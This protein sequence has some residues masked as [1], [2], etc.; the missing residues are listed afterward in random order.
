[1]LCLPQRP[2][3]LASRGHG[4]E[5]EERAR[6][7]GHRDSVACRH[8]VADEQCFVESQ[9]ASLPS[10]ARDGDVDATRVAD[11]QAPQS[12][13]GPMTQDPPV[14][15]SED[16]GHPDAAL[17]ELSMADGVDATVNAMEPA[18]PDAVVDRAPAEAEPGELPRFDEPVLALGD[19]RDRL[20]R[21]RG[22][23]CS[24]YAMHNVGRVGG[25]AIAASLAGR[26]ARVALGAP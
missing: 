21:R 19:R 4:G 17:G 23:R 5:V 10:L 26:S 9:S 13:P 15:G 25:R 18:G 16:S 8:L 3:D 22:R 2:L 6:D 12:G 24:R 11:A 14:P 7:G 20:V 1:M